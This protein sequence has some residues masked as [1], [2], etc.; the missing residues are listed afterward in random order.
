M[1]VNAAD[2]ADLGWQPQYSFGSVLQQLDEGELPRSEL[3]RLIGK[4][5]Y[6]DQ[7]F[8]DGPYPVEGDGEQ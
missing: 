7:V 3:G 5:P 2:R 6:H 4:K 1:Y 8:E